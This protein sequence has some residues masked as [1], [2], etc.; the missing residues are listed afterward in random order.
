MSHRQDDE[1]DDDGARGRSRSVSFDE[2]DDDDDDDNG[3]GGRGRGRSAAFREDDE[4]DSGGGGAAA[5]APPKKR[6]GGT[7]SQKTLNIVSN[8]HPHQAGK[9]AGKQTKLTPEELEERRLAER[10]K[11]QRQKVHGA[12]AAGGRG[13]GKG[14]AKKEEKAYDH[15]I[16]ILLLGD[17]GKRDMLPS[18]RARAQIP[19]FGFSRSLSFSRSLPPPPFWIPCPYGFPVT[20]RIL[21]AFI[22]PVGML[23]FLVSSCHLVSHVTH[24]PHVRRFDRRCW[25]D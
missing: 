16:K 2:N 24:K 20:P 7:V 13:G 19:N 21:T 15:Y 8:L 18:C 14:G 5:P 11:R 23:F 9:P 3:G 17:S 10:E 12:S 1:E 4:D 6:G 25:E 22:N